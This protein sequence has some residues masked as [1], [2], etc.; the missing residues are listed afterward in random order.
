MTIIGSDRYYCER[1]TALRA[2]VPLSARGTGSNAGQRYSIA[3]GDNVLVL[4]A[5]DMSD[6]SYPRSDIPSHKRVIRMEVL[7]GTK[8]VTIDLQG[9][10][11]N[12]DGKK[13]EAVWDFFSLVRTT[14]S[15]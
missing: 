5:M 9:N 11:Y 12:Y 14:K 15:D 7:W 13:R 3:I 2:L 6:L 1:G 10:S 4:A 8:V